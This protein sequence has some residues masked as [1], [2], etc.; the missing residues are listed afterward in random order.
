MK[1]SKKILF[2]YIEKLKILEDFFA[3]TNYAKNKA[4]RKSFDKLAFKINIYVYMFKIK[5]YYTSVMNE[6]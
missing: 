4:L 5:L 3:L 2:Y 1:N 6:V